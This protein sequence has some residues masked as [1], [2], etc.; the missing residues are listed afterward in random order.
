MVHIVARSSTGQEI[1]VM[2]LLTTQQNQGLFGMPGEKNYS[3]VQISNLI[4][5]IRIKHP[6]L[7]LRCFNANGRCE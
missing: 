2:D 4:S 1:Y 5:L 7:G 3:S 6:G